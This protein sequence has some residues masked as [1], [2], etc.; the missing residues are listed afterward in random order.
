MFMFSIKS[1]KSLKYFKSIK[2]QYFILGVIFLMTFSFNFFYSLQ[3]DEFTSGESYT[4]LRKIHYIENNFLPMAWDDLSYSGRTHFDLP[5]FHYF[6]AFFSLFMPIY[7][8]SKFVSALL[9]S[10]LSIIVYF[11]SEKITK[12][13]NVSLISSFMVAFIPSVI[14][15]TFNKVSTFSL[16]IPLLFL[17]FYLFMRI[18][19][20]RKYVIYFVISFILCMITHPMSF[21]LIIAFLV[22]FLIKHIEGLRITKVEAEAVIFLGFFALWGYFIVYKDLLLSLGPGVIWQA[23]PNFVRSDFFKNFDIITAIIR[24]GVLPFLFGVYMIYSFFFNERD[25]YLF[26][27]I[28]LTIFSLLWLKLIQFEAGLSI[29]AISLVILFPH[30]FNLFL[31]YFE[32]TKFSRYENYLLLLIALIFVFTS[33]IPSLN[34]AN[35]NIKNSFNEGEIKALEWINVNTKNN[36]II[37]STENEG[38]FISYKTNRKNV[39]DT[40]YFTIK[41]ADKRLINVRT[42]YTTMF[43]T[44]AIPLLEIYNVDF[45]LFSNRIKNY[46]GIENIKYIN[47]KCFEIVYDEEVQIIK[48]RCKMEVVQRG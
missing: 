29:L 39:I 1:L 18:N 3:A 10:S 8:A 45:I 46:Y 33:L 26:V 23:F 25:N 14:I 38:N 7:L 4:N 5:L 34:Y 9:I 44:E 2:F 47:S 12:R 28:P 24:I 36:A 27:G 40:D 6:V 11:I 37:L 13:S 35:N 20:G 16:F 30:F 17:T 43:E 42:I 22:Y 19:E 31:Q 32:K 15:L 41:D 21:I 48:P